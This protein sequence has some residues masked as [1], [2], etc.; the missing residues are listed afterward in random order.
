MSHV[1][2][3]AAS[4]SATTMPSASALSRDAFDLATRFCAPLDALR[5]A[6]TDAVFPLMTRPW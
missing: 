1:S 5:R 3:K 2:K 4:Q 6:A